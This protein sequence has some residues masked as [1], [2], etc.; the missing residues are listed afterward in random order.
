MFFFYNFF[1][2]IFVFTAKYEGKKQKSYRMGEGVKYQKCLLRRLV[3]R[4]IFRN[5]GAKRKNNLEAFSVD[6]G[7]SRFVI[8]LF[9]NPHLL[10]SGKR[11]KNRTTNPDGIF[12]LWW[13]NDLDLHG[14]W[15]QGGDFLLHAVGDTGVHGGATGKN[16]VGVEVLTDVDIALHDRVVSGLVD[17]GGF[18]SQEGWLEKSLWASE[19]LVTNGNDLP[20]GQ[21]IALFER[22]AGRS[23]RHFLFEVEGNVAEF[24]FD[25]PD[26]FP[27]GGG[28]EGITTLGQDL[29]EVIGEIPSGQVK[30]EDRVG[31]G[32]SLVNGNSVG[33]TITR[34]EDDTSGTTGSVQGKHGLDGDVHGG[35]VESFEHNLGHLFPVGFWVQWGFGQEDWM[36][37]WGDSEFIVESVMPDLFH[38]VPGGD[39][40]VFDWILEG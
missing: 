21:F 4:L 7:W 16:G 33:N 5:L 22:G 36:F 37:L 3:V 28:G 15:C 12:S 40:T 26:D 10:E 11:G 2:L 32:V 23:G 29:H 6:D 1:F 39:D 31:K 8:F 35:G 38:I 20:V 9:R 14:A 13:C 34:I 24:L 18:H 27:L 19:S 17:S 30:T 25:V